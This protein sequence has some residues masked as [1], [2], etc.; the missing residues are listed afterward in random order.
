MRKVIITLS[1]VTILLI[2]TY[3]IL[4]RT[5]YSV[6]ETHGDIQIYTDV[7]QLEEKADLIVQVKITDEKKNHMEMKDGIPFLY[8][9]DTTA[10][11]VE[12]MESSQLQSG[13]LLTIVEPYGIFK[14]NIGYSEIIPHDYN[15]LVPG[16]E[17][18]LF[19]R[20]RDDQR[21]IVIGRSQGAARLNVPESDY[22]PLES[23]IIEKYRNK[24][25]R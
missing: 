16:A 8:W 21:N 13:D 17:Y 5:F 2:G 15:K 6:L 23:M 22:S 9:T 7:T 14:N 4:D 3:M 25:H 18:V 11:V 10:I 20:T 19:L 24:V 1:I 12:S